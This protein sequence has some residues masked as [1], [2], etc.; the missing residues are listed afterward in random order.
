MVCLERKEETSDYH[1]MVYTVGVAIC[2]Y[3]GHLSALSALFQSIEA[4]THRPDQVVVSCSSTSPEDI[5]YDMGSYSFSLQIVTCREKKN[6][7]QN[8]NTAAS[9]LQTDIVTFFDADDLMH[10]QRIAAIHYGFSTHDAYV[11]LHSFQKSPVF[12]LYDE[13]SYD[14]NQLEVCRYGSV[15]VKDHRNKLIAN[16][17]CSVMRHIL[18]EFSYP[19]SAEYHGKEDTVFSARII[20]KYPDHTLYG[21]DVLS[22]YLPSGTG[23]AC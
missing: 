13:Y 17:H 14:V 20:Q 18:D 6:A 23:G 19:E 8:R 3:H 22:C 1:R 11:M 10:P 5:P 12:V 7:A 4:Q 2:C 21:S 16:G 9:Y 15:L